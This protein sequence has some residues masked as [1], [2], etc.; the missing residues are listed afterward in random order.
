VTYDSLKEQR[1]NKPDMR[2]RKHS[3]PEHCARIFGRYFV[4]DVAGE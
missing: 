3:P 4:C 2:A 1:K